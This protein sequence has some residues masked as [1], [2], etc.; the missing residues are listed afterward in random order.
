MWK[1]FIVVITVILATSLVYGEKSAKT[2]P[3]DTKSVRIDENTNTV[4]SKRGITYLPSYPSHVRY[5]QSPYSRFPGI[6]RNP[7][8]PFAPSFAL[9]PGNAVIHSY[10]A[11]YPKYVPKPV[12][13]PAIPPPPPPVFAPRPIIPVSAGS[14]YSNRYPVFVPRPQSVIPRPIVPVSNIPQFSVPNY[15]SSIP[16][17]SVPVP[18]PVP[19]SAP[20]PVPVAFPS[21]INSQSQFI[22]QNG[23]KPFYQPN[24]QAP[25]AHQP[26]VSILPPYT[27]ANL[28]NAQIPQRPAHYYL[29]AGPSASQ[30]VATRSF[31]DGFTQHTN[32][33]LNENTTSIKLD[34]TNI[35]THTIR[36]IDT[37]YKH[38]QIT[39]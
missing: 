21:S 33:K 35:L 3:I 8:N 31:H 6:H 7:F 19:V 1:L 4:K 34:D 17:H 14:V 5:S 23:W 24:I 2:K 26:S 16:T 25:S 11:S 37:L 13:R 9:T 30:D 28:A 32:G 27:S 39:G 36:D 20:S 18:Y 38:Q 12:F 29:P 15:V 22:A 10:S